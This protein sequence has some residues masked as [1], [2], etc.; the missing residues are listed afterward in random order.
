MPGAGGARRR[1][2]AWAARSRSCAARAAR[3]FLRLG[4]E[5]RGAGGSRATLPSLLAERRR[6]GRRV[7]RRGTRRQRRGRLPRGRRRGAAA[8]PARGRRVHGRGARAPVALVP[9][10]GA[11]RRRRRRGRD[12]RLLRDPLRRRVGEAGAAMRRRAR[13]PRC[14]RVACRAARCVERVQGARDPAQPGRAADDGARLRHVHADHRRAST[15]CEFSARATDRV[16]QPL[17][18]GRRRAD[19]P[20][21]PREARRRARSCSSCRPRRRCRSRSRAARLP[22]DRAA[23]VRAT[24]RRDRSSRGR[25]SATGTIGD[26]DGRA[27]DLPVN[28]IEPCGPP[29]QF[30]F[31]P[32]GGTCA[33][34]CGASSHV[35]VRR[36]RRGAVCA[37]ARTPRYA[38]GQG[39]ID[40]RSIGAGRAGAARRAPGFARH[41]RPGAGACCCSARS[42]TPSST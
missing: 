35:V 2:A 39:G 20:V 27:L 1:S 10:D 26:Y 6:V 37:S 30:F 23:T 7:L 25:P 32:D 19:E 31:L 29:E 16:Q 3:D 22:G 8:L 14:S 41:L 12:R 13:A 38:S 9:V 36:R 34:V 40:Y 24:A 5:S 42:L 18:A 11:G 17:R 21:R 15:T 33:E 28:V 4:L